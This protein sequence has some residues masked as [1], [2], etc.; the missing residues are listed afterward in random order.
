MTAPV[1][2]GATGA[3]G[4]Q[5]EWWPPARWLTGSLALL[6]ALVLLDAA[7]RLAEYAATGPD[8]GSPLWRV[9]FWLGILR[10]MTPV[11]LGGL[12][13]CAGV[14]A[15]GGERTPRRVA[16]GLVALA[17]V[18]FLAP[19]GGLWIDRAAA[20]LEVAPAGRP[21]F[22]RE[23]LIGVFHGLAGGGLGL[24]AAVVLARGRGDR[25]SRAA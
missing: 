16:V 7:L 4:D 15:R 1:A 25:G 19:L 10:Q 21:T 3:V 14:L 9:N 2:E 17:V 12:V 22:E 18:A 8:P 6:G 5:R 23:V 11:V 20:V 13:L 24:A